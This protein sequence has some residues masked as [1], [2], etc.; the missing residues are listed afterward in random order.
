MALGPVSNCAQA[1]ERTRAENV[2]FVEPDI[3]QLSA[4]TRTNGITTRAELNNTNFIDI[5][6]SFLFAGV[7]LALYHQNSKTKFFKPQY[8]PQYWTRN[9][10]AISL[11]FLFYRLSPGMNRQ[12]MR[13]GATRRRPERSFRTYAATISPYET[14]SFSSRVSETLAI[15]SFPQLE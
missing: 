15:G 9:G 13:G 4:A 12:C 7:I 2:R 6:V 14:G 10:T 8:S 3:M 1:A 11:A 5:F